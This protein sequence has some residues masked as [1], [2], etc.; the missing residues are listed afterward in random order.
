MKLTSTPQ[1][2]RIRLIKLL[3]SKKTMSTAKEHGV[4]YSRYCLGI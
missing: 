2:H 3:S 1:R 4:N